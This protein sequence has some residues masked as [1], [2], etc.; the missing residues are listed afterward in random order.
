MGHGGRRPGAGRKRGSVNLVTKALREK[1][2]ANR[3]IKFLHDVADGKVKGASV[4]ERN[5]AAI[6]LMDKILPDRKYMELEAESN[7]DFKLIVEDYRSGC[8]ADGAVT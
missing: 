7:N 5:R 1:I 6:A 2:D 4:S 8:T 3:L